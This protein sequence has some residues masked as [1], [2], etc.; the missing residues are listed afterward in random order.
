MRS[1][2]CAGSPG[3]VIEFSRP[4]SLGCSQRRHA[5][6]LDHWRG[7]RIERWATT[8]QC[9]QVVVRS[10]VSR[11]ESHPFYENL[12]YARTKTQHAYRKVLDNG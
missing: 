9:T 4:Y 5:A 11:S 1:R 2:G 6:G 7:A 12:G 8:R 10:N 3:S